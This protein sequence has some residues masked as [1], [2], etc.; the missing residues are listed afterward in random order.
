MAD[1][2]VTMSGDVADILRKQD[3]VTKRQQKQIDKLKDTLKASKAAGKG[4]QD[5][6]VKGRNAFGK[7]LEA[8]LTASIGKVFAL[9]KAAQLVG[10]AMQFVRGETDKAIASFGRLEESR[11]ALTQIATSAE[12]LQ[13]LETKADTLA[14]KH[15]VDREVSRRVLFSARSEGFEGFASDII[16]FSPVIAPEAA[17]AAAGQL[18]GL[19]PGSGLEPRQAVNAALTAAKASRLNFEDLAKALPAAAEG[20][21]AAGAT[22]AE[23]FATASTLASRF[24]SGESAADRIK[25]LGIAISLDEELKGKGLLDAVKELEAGSKE[26]R[27]KFLGSSSELNSAFRV[28]SEEMATILE[29]QKMV[30]Q[31]IAQSGTQGSAL[32]AALNARFDTSNDVG[33]LAT[34]KRAS[35]RARISREITNERTEAQSGMGAEAA[36][37]GAMS[38]L[39]KAGASG[40][41]QFMGSSAASTARFFGVEDKDTLR[42]L[43]VGVADALSFND[44]GALATRTDTIAAQRNGQP[45]DSLD[46]AAANSERATAMQE[47]ANQKWLNSLQWQQ[48]PPQRPQFSEANRRQ[49]AVPTE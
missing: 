42:N 1:V 48:P 25:A 19:F 16:K 8:G 4:L 49:Q 44:A 28:I 32:N 43:A 17:A 9:Q 3:Q 15:G 24:K 22:P 37:D 2:V 46:R 29:R 33:Q 47:Q 13:Q 20:A 21:G 34:A 30:E 35:D 10:S 11:R 5:A 36:I 7:R 6:G 39:K 38:D 26:R 14:A 27:E 41:S 18:P 40:F 23:T 31:A 45:N 12:D